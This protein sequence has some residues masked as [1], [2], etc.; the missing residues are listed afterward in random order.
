[1]MEGRLLDVIQGTGGPKMS[2]NLVGTRPRDV[3]NA[4]QL[5]RSHWTRAQRRERRLLA[6]IKQRQLPAL[7]G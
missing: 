6:V 3:R 2:T 7:G 5:I 1:M 4:C